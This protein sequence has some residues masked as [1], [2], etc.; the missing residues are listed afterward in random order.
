MLLYNFWSQYP[1]LSLLL[2]KAFLLLNLINRWRSSKLT[3]QFGCALIPIYSFPSYFV[4]SS[5]VRPSADPRRSTDALS[6]YSLLIQPLASAFPTPIFGLWLPEKA[7]I[8]EPA[9]PIYCLEHI[10]IKKLPALQHRPTRISQWFLFHYQGT[11]S[12]SRKVRI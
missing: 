9:L 8:K 4:Y 11:S 12:P 2:N 3:C 5:L 7:F 10:P 1:P 6:S